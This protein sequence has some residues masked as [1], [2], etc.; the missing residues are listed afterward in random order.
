[1]RRR[2]IILEVSSS[3]KLKNKTKLVKE[4][5]TFNHRAKHFP[6][7]SDKTA[8]PTINTEVL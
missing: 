1:M 4:A 5:K 7:A 2:R 3:K 8:E 6:L